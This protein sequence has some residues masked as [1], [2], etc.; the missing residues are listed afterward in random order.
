[1]TSPA[2]IKTWLPDELKK[3]EAIINSLVKVFEE[4]DYQPIEIP[5]LVD[6]SVIQ[7][8]NRRF[9]ADVFKVVDRDGKTLALR[10]ELTQPIAKTISTRAQEINF[11]AKIF[12]NSSVFRYRGIAT[13]DSR[14]IRQVGVELFDKKNF[15]NTSSTDKEIIKILL[16]SLS[17]LELKNFKISITDAKI[18]HKIFQLYGSLEAQLIY[19]SILKGDLVEFKKLS[20]NRPINSLMTAKCLEDIEKSLDI[21]LSNLAELLKISDKIVFDPLQCPDIQLY[22]G[23]HI[24]LVVPGE[25]KLIAIG[26]RYDN[27]C[28]EF[29]ADLSAIGFAFYIPRLISALNSQKL[30]PKTGNKLRIAIAKGTLFDGAKSYLTDKGFIV[31]DT[32]KRKLIIPVKTTTP[33]GFDEIEILMVR[34]HDVPTYV[35]HGAA[36]LGIVGYD[37]ILDSV[38]DIFQLEDLDYGH[39]RLCVCAKKGVYKSIADMPAYTRVATTFPKITKDFFAQKGLEIEVINLY[40]SVELGP[41][42][43]LSDVIVD[44]VASGKTLEENGLEVVQEIL[45]CTARLIANHASYKNFK[46]AI[47]ELLAITK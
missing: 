27:L 6:I 9:N 46:H 11:P 41:L 7:K 45:P 43:D 18:W 33:S 19:Q 2:G 14:E 31:P 26:G 39:C 22:T 16:E 30:N 29:G 24:N 8:A 42:T 3:Q 47:N 17:K 40:G 15:S 36:D 12:Y 35:D 37:V 10:T 1:M 34:G 13:D 20:A 21:D 38:S 5:T 23:L 44:L 28:K 4:H 25:G 32:E